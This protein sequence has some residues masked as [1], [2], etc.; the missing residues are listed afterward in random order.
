MFG[1]PR[2]RRV[3]DMMRQSYYWPL[4]IEDVYNYVKKFQSCRRHK[5]YPTH[6][7]LLKLFSLEAPMTFVTM[8]ILEPLPKTK[9]GI[10]FIIVMMDHY[11]K[12]ARGIW[13]RKTTTTDAARIF[14][15]VLVMPY[16]IPDRLLT[17]RGQQFL[18]KVFNA[19]CVSLGTRPMKMAAFRPQTNRKTEWYNKNVVGRLCHF[20]SENQHD[21]NTFV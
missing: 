14:V 21:W 15:E 16:G 1:H 4:V 12:L 5:Q 8:D 18:G 13:T 20:I 10:K 3:Y 11:S 19:V 6:R 17:G 7:L 9:S 2:A